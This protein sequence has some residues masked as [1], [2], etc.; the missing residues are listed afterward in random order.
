MMFINTKRNIS[1]AIG[2]PFISFIYPSFKI[3]QYSKVHTTSYVHFLW[4]LLQRSPNAWAM[5]FYFDIYSIYFLS[6]ISSPNSILVLLSSC[7]FF[8]KWII[9]QQK[10]S[11]TQCIVMDSNAKF[12]T[13]WKCSV[14]EC[15]Q[16]DWNFILRRLF[17]LP[18]FSVVPHI[19]H[20]DVLHFYCH[21]LHSWTISFFLWNANDG[22]DDGLRINANMNL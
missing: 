19:L 2:F 20:A 21:T 5:F 10:Y 8:P 12:I 9:L 18:K 14:F 4:N 7:T 3:M 6:G 22:R 11:V 17:S 15:T 1:I 13:H 16:L